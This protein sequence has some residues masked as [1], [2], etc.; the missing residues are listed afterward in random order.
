MSEIIIRTD[1][2]TGKIDM[3]IGGKPIQGVTDFFVGRAS[4]SDQF[5]VLYNFDILKTYEFSVTPN[6]DTG[7]TAAEDG[8]TISRE[9]ATDIAHY[10]DKTK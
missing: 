7:T 8:Y 3:T 9:L 6:P 1:R 4:G 10:L 2:K 5:K